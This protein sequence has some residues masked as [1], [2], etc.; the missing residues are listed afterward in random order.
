MI[1]YQNVSMAYPDSGK[2]LDDL[3]FEIKRGSFL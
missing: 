2:V 1:K 3:N